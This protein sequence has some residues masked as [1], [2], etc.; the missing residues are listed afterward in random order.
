MSIIVLSP[1]GISTSHL[2][3]TS[4]QI[5]FWMFATLFTVLL[6]AELGIMFKQIKVGPKDGGQ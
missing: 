2:S 5:T 6:I 1:V 4:V 3:T